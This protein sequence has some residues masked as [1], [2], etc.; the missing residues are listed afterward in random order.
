[1]A[2]FYLPPSQWQ[3]GQ[4]CLLGDEARHC[5]RVLRF[6]AGEECVLF[7]GI[8]QAKRARV[9]SVE[10]DKC[11]EC[12]ILE[13]LPEE[14]SPL[15]ITLCQSIAKGGNMELII[16]KAVELGVSK[17][18]P[19]MT[20]RTIA[21]YQGK[22]A[23]SKQE[24]WQRIALEACKQ[25]GQNV[26]P[27]VL[28][29]LSFGAWAQEEKRA[30]EKSLAQAGLGL[31]ASLATGARG[32]REVLEEARQKE[33]KKVSYLVGPEGDFTPAETEKALELG[34]VPITLGSIVL[35][36]ETAT[37]MGLSVL[38]YALG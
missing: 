28:E 13:D 38:R 31:V 29:P 35:R 1:M 18:I 25:C 34:F 20:E 16:Q 4:W 32:L 37:F 15:E 21:R 36:V 2:R 22:E 5:V 7:N 14:A 24:K 17:I 30:G 23:R 3:E 8:G 12:E 11:V 26:L 33:V 19:L 10:S 27:E 6:K 9:L